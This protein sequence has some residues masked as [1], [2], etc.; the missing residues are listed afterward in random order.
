M[1]FVKVGRNDLIK[2]LKEYIYLLK[3]CPK[4]MEFHTLIEFCGIDKQFLNITS[5][6][7]LKKALKEKDTEQNHREVD[8]RSNL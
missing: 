5:N 3:K 1:Q 8:L 6:Y 4:N 7:Y 2:Q